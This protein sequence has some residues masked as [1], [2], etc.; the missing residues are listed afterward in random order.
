MT[1]WGFLQNF[2]AVQPIPAMYPF[3]IFMICLGL[4][5]GISQW[6]RR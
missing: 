5:Q 2:A 1:V 4:V 3:F 6:W